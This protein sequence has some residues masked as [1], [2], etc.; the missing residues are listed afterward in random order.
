MKRKLACIFASC[1]LAVAAAL[2]VSAADAEGTG[3]VKSIEQ[4]AAPVV[5]E[6]NTKATLTVDGEEVEVDGKDLTFY[7]VHLELT[8]LSKADQAPDEQITENLKGAASDVAS[9]AS[10]SDMTFGKEEDAQAFEDAK[11]AAEANGNELV[12]TNIF[13]LSL[14][15]NADGEKVPCGAITVKMAVSN[16][17]DLVLVTHKP[18]DT[19]EVVPFTNNGDGTITVTLSS[20]SP[21]A[22]FVEADASVVVPEIPDS[23]SNPE[24]SS[25]ESESSS[26]STSESSSESSSDSSSES[27]SSKTD[28]SASS[29]SS[30]SKAASSSTTTSPNTGAMGGAAFAVPAV[31]AVAGAVVLAK[32]SKKD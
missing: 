1:L 21:L 23:S 26:E 13:D 19:W 28:S 6:D 8:P 2:P 27:S 15:S 18:D 22:F 10:S 9:T 12:C 16:A 31:I 3:F 30:S 5:D 14:V 29:A 4:Q 11:A 24:P 20:L 32:K 7:G 25:S 17:D